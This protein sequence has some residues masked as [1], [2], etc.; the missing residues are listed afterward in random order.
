MRDNNPSLRPSEN[1]AGP[2]IRAEPSHL[3][4]NGRDPDTEACPA[5]P[6]R[7]P[8]T[9]NSQHAEKSPPRSNPLSQGYERPGYS[10][11]AILA[12]LCIITYPIFYILTRVAKDKSLL[13]VRSIASVWCSGVGFALGYIILKI[14]SQ[15][16]EAASESTLVEYRGFLRHYLPQTAWATVIHMSYDG[17]GMKLHDLASNSDD[18]TSPLTA[19]CVFWSRFRNRQTVGRRSRKSYESVSSSSSTLCLLKFLQQTAV[20]PI[21]RILRRPHHPASHTA[22]P[23]RTRCVDRNFRGCTCHRPSSLYQ[24]ILGQS[25]H[26]VYREVLVAGDLSVEDIIQANSSNTSF[27][28]S[29][30]D[31]TE[32]VYDGDTVYFA[33]PSLSQFV[34]GGSGAGNFNPPKSIG[35][36]DPANNSFPPPDPA[37]MIRKGAKGADA[38]LRY[39]PP[40]H[41]RCTSPS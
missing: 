5:R 31:T 3:T 18:A 1:P 9:A 41:R 15:Y 40:A 6:P 17:G 20:V 10:R 30:P 39:A 27:S 12:A 14:G 29:V 35:Q 4:P 21:H 36:K 22:F 34:P 38:I 23:I 19:V 33:Q 11:L 37:S 26:D 2:S 24:L 28:E 8:S 7:P 25:Q 16:L 13:I 32:L